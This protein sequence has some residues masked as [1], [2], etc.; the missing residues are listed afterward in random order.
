MKNIKLI[1]LTILFGCSYLLS[2]SVTQ[3]K[4]TNLNEELNDK[5]RAVIPLAERIRKLPGIKFYNGVPVVTT[6]ANSFSNSNPEPLYVL[7]GQ[8]IGNSYTSI[9]EL[10]DS[11][12]V[13]SVKLIKGT[14]AS[15]YGTQGA[16]GVIFIKTRQ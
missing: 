9:L 4:S 10:I 3:T 2:C 14:E 12:N 7:N 5:N 15:F 1:A 13:A 16:N 6:S 11:N 8:V